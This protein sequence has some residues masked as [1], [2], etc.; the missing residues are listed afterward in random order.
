[1]AQWGEYRGQ[2]RRRWARHVKENEDVLA[3][4]RGSASVVDALAFTGFWIH[5]PES[6]H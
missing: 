5:Q 1:M 4:S 3:A 2:I 6:S